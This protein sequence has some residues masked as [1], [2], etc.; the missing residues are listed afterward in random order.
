M[1][2]LQPHK[3]AS[4]FPAIP[5]E[6]FNQLVQDIRS[7]GLLEPIW[8][9][10]GKVLD[11]WHRY[12]AAK[13]A[14]VEPRA[15]EWRGRDPLAFVVSM[16]VMRRHLNKGQRALLLVQAAEQEQKLAKRG[17]Q[18]ESAETADLSTEAIAKTLNVSERVVSQARRVA[19]EPELPKL[20]LSGRLGVWCLPA[21]ALCRRGGCAGLSPGDTRR[22]VPGCER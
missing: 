4:L 3:L 6:E 20:V 22:G 18:S 7:G 15:R 1:T 13:K 10:E 12:R 11:G 14:G 8:L 21:G 17:G 5:E 2:T 16:N 9:Y 19:K